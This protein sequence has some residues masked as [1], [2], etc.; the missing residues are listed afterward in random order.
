MRILVA[1]R[2]EIACRILSSAKSLG[3]DTVAVFSEADACS[4]HVTMADQAILLGPAPAAESYLNM[5]RI[6]QAARDS[7]ADA[8]HPGYGFL[9]ENA[10]FA[11]ACEAANLRFIGPPADAI[12]LMGNKAAAK[13]HMNAADVPCVPGYNGIQQDDATF[14]A[15]ANDI[16]FPVMVKA[17]AGGGRRGIRRVEKTVDL[18][19]ALRLARSEAE[20]AFGSAELILEKAIERPRHVEIQILA[21]QHGAVIHLG[22]RDCSIQR[23]HQKVVEEAPCPVM[24]E[25]LR[26][27]MGEVAV[28][29][30]KSIGYVGAGTVEFLLSGAEDFYFL[31]MNTRLQVEHPVTEMVTGLDLVALQIAIAQGEHLPL[32]QNEVAFNGHAIEVRLYAEDPSQDFIPSTGMIELWKAPVV[33]GVRVDDGVRTGLS[34]TPY[35]DAMVAKIIGWDDSRKMARCRLLRA[36]HE[37]ALFG[38]SSNRDFLIRILQTP[39][40]VDGRATTAFLSEARLEE[41][42]VPGL[43]AAQ[44]AA[45][46][47][48]LAYREQ[49]R[50][51]LKASLLVCDELSHWGSAGSLVS[52]LT[53]DAPG[54]V[55]KLTVRATQTGYTVIEG[56][57]QCIIQVAHDD[58]VSATVMIEKLSHRATYCMTPDGAVWLSVDGRIECYL[59][60]VSGADE[61]DEASTGLVRAPM[62]GVLL[63]IL[64]SPGDRV[65]RGRPLLVLEAMKMQHE[66]IAPMDGCIEQV[67]FGLGDHVA[68]DEV[69][70]EIGVA[71]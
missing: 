70:L 21:D 9:S 45:V 47:A 37:T 33:E 29:A 39:A 28:T 3:H 6:L 61:D 55:V 13:I 69:I 68:A 66:V 46:A 43:T 52:R 24:T 56:D 44:R 7:G 62:H 15:A 60:R 12:E 49:H 8:I 35:Y 1:N 42:S 67:F 64:V 27:R 22:E 20:R 19:D 11:R 50:K 16:G 10:A 2:G 48:V 38:L 65:E 30:A 31:E 23:R 59:N 32:Q 17:A 36:L 14:A 63:K 51:A 4:P 41:S 26:E 57:S 71:Q 40:F 53:L 18:P 58:G 25:Q 34:I 5:E 54:G